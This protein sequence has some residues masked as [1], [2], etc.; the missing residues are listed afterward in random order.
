MVHYP[1]KVMQKIIHAIICLLIA[2]ILSFGQ[3][4]INFTTSNGQTVNISCE[5]V[6]TLSYDAPNTPPMSNLTY[7]P[8]VNSVVTICPQAGSATSVLF[9]DSPPLFQWNVP[10]GDI[11]NIYDGENTGAPLIG[12]FNSVTDP[13]GMQVQSTGIGGGNPS[14]CLTIE[15]ISAPGGTG[16]E[17]GGQLLCGDIWQPFVP[18]IATT[19]PTDPTG[20]TIK[21]CFPQTIDLSATGNFTWMPGDPG[22]EQT[23]A[24]SFFTWTMGDGTTYEGLGL[25]NVTHDYG[26]TFGYYVVVSVQDAEGQVQRDSMVVQHSTQVQFPG[27]DIDNDTICVGEDAVIEWQG[28]ASPGGWIP[29]VFSPEGT[30]FFGGLF[31]EQVFIPD[32][33]GAVVPYETVIDVGGFTPGATITSASD[34]IEICFNMEHSYLGDLEMQIVCPDGTAVTI[35][36]CYVAGQGSNPGQWIPGGFNPGGINLGEPAIGLGAGIGYTYCFSEGATDYGTFEEEWAAGNWD[37]PTTA[38]PPGSYQ[39]MGSFDD[40]VGCP[41]NGEWSLQVVDNWGAD[42]GYI[43]S[44]G[45]QIDQG[46]APEQDT[47]QPNIVDLVWTEAPGN[48]SAPTITDLN[49]NDS[50]L[51]VTPG[52]SG[53]YQYILTVTDDFDCSY[54]T[55]MTLTVGNIPGITVQD[56][57]TI[58]CDED[59]ALEVLVDGVGPPPT[60]C[61][62]VLELSDAFGDGWTGGFVEVIVDGASIGTY[63]L[64]N[65]VDD[66][67]FASFNIPVTHMGTIQ[68]I[69]TGGGGSF[70]NSYSLFGANGDL[71]FSDGNPPFVPPFNG[72][73]YVGDTDCQGPGV[74]YNY[75]WTPE[76]FLDNPDIPNPNATGISASTTFVVEVYEEPFSQCVATGSVTVGLLGEL[77]AGPDIP[78][79]E[80]SYPISAISYLNFGVWSA[81]PGSGITFDDPLSANTTVTA[82][83]PGTYVLTW[84]DPSGNS[85][86]QSDEIVVTFLD[87]IDVD[88]TLTEPSCFGDCNGML[89]ANPIGGTV[90]VEYFYEW[91][92]TLLGPGEDIA[93]GL[94]AGVYSV[95]VT[96]DNGCAFTHDAAVTQP[97]EVVIDSVLTQR[98]ECVGFC[99]GEITVFS[100]A[101]TQY[102]F[103]GGATFGPDNF[104]NEA[105]AGTAVIIVQDNN[106]CF[107]E[108]SAYVDSPIPPIADFDAESGRAT[109]INPQFHFINQSEGNEQ[110]FWSFGPGGLYGTST[111]ID[112]FFTFPNEVGTYMTT[113]LVIDSIGCTDT[114]TRTVEVIDEYLF[115]LPNSFSPNGDGVNDYLEAFGGDILASDFNFQI[116]DRWGR[117]VYEA[118]DFPFRWDGGG[119]Q[120]TDYFLEAGVYVWRMQTKRAS[121]TDKIEQQGHV[122]IIR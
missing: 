111:E 99:N 59:I 114:L 30:F 79:C 89:E 108:T 3:A 8:G 102:S 16:G 83:V 37:F 48:P 107:K 96:D 14:G 122:T 88:F 100:D 50:T 52:L 68:L 82:T 87:Q 21:T 5:N 61:F 101:A 105:C 44:W 27:V 58:D 43:F 115:F 120:N 66:G 26:G 110:N 15:I 81:P 73:S 29:G 98:E 13:D 74:T 24:N 75:S 118:T 35:F 112:P 9:F 32:W 1:N 57:L 97:A 106:G 6:N 51:T 54:D 53:T 77:N 91:S 17:L 4:D 72:L 10:D 20:D 42:N 121:T 33:G 71:L 94:C 12:S 25:S 47:Y 90:A 86:P 62:Y 23:D 117:M 2:P 60:D 64:D 39:P 95:T 80:M 113:L 45:I 49:Y 31:G 103:D 19:L 78:G 104:Y 85:C 84:A 18:S 55:T 56:D 116:Y 69:F 76:D 119:N 7:P 92:T 93:S 38:V 46:L 28:E 11:I 67:T 34:I 63:T 41:V 36:D 40:L 22:Y 109:V 70:E 65:V